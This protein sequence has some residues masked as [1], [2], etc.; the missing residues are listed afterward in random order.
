MAQVA[1]IYPQWR[2]SPECFKSAADFRCDPAFY[3][4]FADYF[5]QK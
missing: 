5:Q 3:L 1:Q 2:N 4:F